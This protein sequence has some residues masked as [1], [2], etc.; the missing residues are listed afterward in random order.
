[1][2]ILLAGEMNLD[3]VLLC[4]QSFPALGKEVLVEDV[5]LT[6]GGSSAICA[7]GLVKL[8][9]R[10]SLLAKLGCDSFGTLHLD[11]LVQLGVDRSSSGEMVSVPGF[12]VNPVDTTGAGDSFNAGFLHA[13]LRGKDLEDAMRFA[14]CGALST[15]GIGE[16]AA[17][18][19][20]IHANDFVPKVQLPNPT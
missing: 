2:K 6:L 19:S 1:M 10:V 13:W 9:D 12:P 3:L 4:Y 7:A 8:R 14:V 20:E 18:A 5:S 17:Q 15:Q 11:E 16:T